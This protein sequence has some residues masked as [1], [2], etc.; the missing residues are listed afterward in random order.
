MKKVSHD[1][2]SKILKAIDDYDMIKKSDTIVV[3]VSGGSDSM[4]LLNFLLKI[5]AKLSLKIIVAHVNHCLRGKESDRDENFVRNFCE[6]NNILFKLLKV[7]VKKIAKEKKIGLEECGRQIRYEFFNSL[8]LENYKIATAHNLSDYAET[9]IFN[10]TRGTGINGLLGIRAKRDNIIR[11]LLYLKKSEI[12]KYCKD[13]NISYVDDSTNFLE[14]YARNKIRL[15]VIPLLTEIN[16]NLENNILNMGDILSKDN[17]YLNKLAD[18]SLNKSKIGKNIYSLKFLNDLDISLRSRCVR[19]IISDFDK[20]ISISHDK[21]KIILD[22]M[23]K[24]NGMLNV[25]KEIFIKV[26]EESI[27]IFEANKEEGIDKWEIELIKDNT[28]LTV[29]KKVFIIKVM[30]KSFYD[31]LEKDSKILNYALD[32]DKVPK[33]SLLRNRREHDRYRPKNRN[34]SKS[35]KKFFNE[36][37]LDL[38]KRYNIS[39]IANKNEIL[40]IE[41]FGSSHE[42][43]VTDETKKVLLIMEKSI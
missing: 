29:N 43:R 16:S 41:S 26:N 22:M 42:A 9:V 32:F 24:E 40:W 14:D 28:V 18:A 17:N 1:L 3:G 13:N 37:K 19:K 15:N 23:E 30:S 5:S 8:K 39:M 27:E 6:D 11:P 10:L 31:S 38:S 4:L 21:V 35:L 34:L 20:E 25:C 36:Q 12:V 2:E 33:G 7:D